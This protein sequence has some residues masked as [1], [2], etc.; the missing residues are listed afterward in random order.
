M[1]K[2]Y[3][4]PCYYAN[5]PIIKMKL[6]TLQTEYELWQSISRKG[7]QHSTVVSIRTGKQ[8][9]LYRKRPSPNTFLPFSACV[10]LQMASRK[11]SATVSTTGMA[12]TGGTLDSPV[13]QI[14]IEGLVS[15]ITVL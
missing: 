5:G 7:T 4:S 14:Q 8:A 6:P 15:V 9:H 11:E 2:D 12:S 10:G 3:I 13:K 1:R